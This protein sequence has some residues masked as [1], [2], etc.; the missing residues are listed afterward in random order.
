MDPNHFLRNTPTCSLKLFSFRCDSRWRRIRP[1]LP[2]AS[3][4]P[5]YVLTLCHYAFECST[6]YAAY[7]HRTAMRHGTDT[8]HSCRRTSESLSQLFDAVPDDAFHE[9]RRSSIM[10]ADG[11]R[12]RGSHKVPLGLYRADGQKA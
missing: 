12:M 6:N 7:T 9:N 11:I 10:H 4:S 3:G 1:S 2:L 5:S 8:A